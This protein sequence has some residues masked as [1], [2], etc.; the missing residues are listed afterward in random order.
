MNG[1]LDLKKKSAKWKVRC[2]PH[3]IILFIIYAHEKK[4]FYMWCYARTFGRR[5][6]PFGEGKL[7]DDRPCRLLCDADMRQCKK[8][9]IYLR[10]L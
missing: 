6:D 7:Y 2:I 8:E 9:Q 1:D 4:E 3:S 10:Q 5:D